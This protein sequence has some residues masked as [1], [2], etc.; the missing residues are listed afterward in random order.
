MRDDN[1]TKGALIFSHLQPEG[2]C[3]LGQTLA[4]RGM[5]IRTINTPREGLEDIDPLRP[6]LPIVMGGPVGVYQANDYPFLKQ[7]IEILKQ[8][9]AADLPTIGICLGSQLMAAALGATVRPG[10]QGKE[11]GWIGLNVTEAGQ[12]SL[13]KHLNGTQTSMFHWHGDTFD[14][15]EGAALHASTDQYE[16]QIY[17]YGKKA[18]GLQC[19]PEVQEQQLEEWYVMFQ[20]DITGNNPLIPV[21][22]LRAQTKEHIEILNRQAKIFFNAWLDEVGL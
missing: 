1:K 22:E 5:R 21:Q 17:T 16:N 8:R 14:L 6:D 7:E 15:P 20:K 2:S 10:E 11:V 9:L 12:S 19:H 13:V 4:E 3:T 18:L